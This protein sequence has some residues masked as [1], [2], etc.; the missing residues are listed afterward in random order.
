MLLKLRLLTKRHA[1]KKVA[2]LL[3]K[4]NNIKHVSHY[5]HFLLLFVY[6]F[7]LTIM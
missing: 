4:E 7:S 2:E 5:Q 3:R 6:H 1:K